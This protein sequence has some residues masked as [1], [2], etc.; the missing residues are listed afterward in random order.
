MEN[1]LVIFSHDVLDDKIN[2]AIRYLFHN[3]YVT[4]CVYKI[5]YV[6]RIED[7][8][9][10]YLLKVGYALFAERF[11]NLCIQCYFGSSNLTC[12]PHNA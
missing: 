4:I 3:S 6:W 12:P 11:A 5:G 7:D 2:K 1:I 8:N 10:Y 9:K